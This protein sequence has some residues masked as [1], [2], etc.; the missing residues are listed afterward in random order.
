MRVRTFQIGGASPGRGMLGWVLFM[1]AAVV[2]ILLFLVAAFFGVLVLTAGSLIRL[3]LSPIHR[4]GGS[5]VRGPGGSDTD[6]IT[7]NRGEDGIWRP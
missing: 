6:K 7:M 2:G 3:V 1:F 4:S 5:A